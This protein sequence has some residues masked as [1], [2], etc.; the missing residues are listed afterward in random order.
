[1]KLVM[2]SQ[3]PEPLGVQDTNSAGVGETIRQ[4]LDLLP[5]AVIAL[6]ILSVGWLLAKLLRSLAKG[7]ANRFNGLISRSFADRP[8]IA[9]HLS[10]P[11]I[12]VIGDVVFWSV[13]LVSITAAANAAGLSV[14]AGWLVGVLTHIPNLLTALAI[15]VAGYLLSLFVRDQWQPEVSGLPGSRSDQLW[16]NLIQGTVLG[17]TFIV[18]LDQLG[19]DVLL[20]IAL[21]CV[22]AGSLLLTLGLSFALGARTHVSNL[23]GARAARSQ[24][25][26]GLRIRIGDIEGQVVE[27]SRVQIILETGSGKVL[28]PAHLVDEQVVTILTSD[29]QAAAD[30]NPRATPD[31]PDA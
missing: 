29:Q 23:I 21:A 15:F 13:I 10:K 27:L 12:T 8:L 25:H 30:S 4:G 5:G 17:A 7:L 16:G 11:M 31:K 19:V 1:M 20:L 24:L 6:L 26:A 18:G 22:I 2:I 3:N 9:L 14:I 28:I